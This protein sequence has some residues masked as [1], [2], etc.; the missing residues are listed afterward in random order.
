MISKCANPNCS[1]AFRYFREGELF[2]FDK[3][4]SSEPRVNIEGVAKGRM[5]HRLENF[6]L[7]ANCASSLVVRMIQG[8]AEVVPRGVSTTHATNMRAGVD[9]LIG[10]PGSAERKDTRV[11]IQTEK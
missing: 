4:Y 6:W 3:N 1:A 5:P 2:L 9:S 10:I 7:C 11:V 8:K